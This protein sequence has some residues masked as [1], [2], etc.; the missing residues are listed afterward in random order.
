MKSLARNFLGAC[1]YA[2]PTETTVVDRLKRD[3]E[4]GEDTEQGTCM[5]SCISACMIFFVQVYKVWPSRSVL[6]I[7]NAKSDAGG[8]LL[9]SYILMDTYYDTF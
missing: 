9:V 6:E 4:K 1:W 5:I 2:D 8:I 7:N 3:S